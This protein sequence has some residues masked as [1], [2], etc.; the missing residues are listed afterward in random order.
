MEVA[1]QNVTAS[2]LCEQRDFVGG[3]DAA[4]KTL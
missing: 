4:T 3:W 2:D 1:M